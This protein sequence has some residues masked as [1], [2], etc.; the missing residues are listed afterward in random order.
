M[1][2]QVIKF[3]YY[4]LKK[5]Y[6]YLKYKLFFYRYDSNFE[7]NDF[8][9]INLSVKNIEKN[10]KKLL[11]KSANLA[12][13]NLY[14]IL[15][16]EKV[17][18]KG[19]DIWH[20]DF[21]SGYQWKKYTYYS[22]IKYGDK[23]G[24]DV[25]IPWE[26]S[27]NHHLVT[28]A[29]AYHLTRN[30][31]YLKK[32]LSDIHSW[33]DSN[34]IFYGV[35]WVCPMEVAIRAC[36]FLVAYSIF[37]NSAEINSKIEEKILFSLAEH[38]WFIR[39][40]LEKTFDGLTSNHYLADLM[41]LVFLGSFF[42]HTDYGKKWL[43]F[44]KQELI[45]EMDTQVYSDGSDYEASTAY[46]KLV[47]EFFFYATFVLVLN[48]KN[49][50]SFLTKAK[51]ILGFEFLNK[52]HKMF[53]VLKTVTK[54]N[55]EIS[56]F[57]DNDSGTVFH[58][59]QDVNLDSSFLL[60]LGSLFFKD[61]NLI[62]TDFFN[63]SVKWLFPVGNTSKLKLKPAANFSKS[64][65]KAGW[66]RLQN[67]K[68]ICMISAGPIGQTKNS[69]HSHNDKLSFEL[70]IKNENIIVDPG[71]Y[72]YTPQK[73]WRNKF[74]STLSHNTIRINR[75][76]QNQLFLKN[77]FKVQKKSESKIKEYSFKKKSKTCCFELKYKKFDWLH[78]RIFEL[79]SS[80]LKIQDHIF[81]TNIKELEWSFIFSPQ[82]KLFDNKKSFLKIKS[83]TQTL[84]FLIDEKLSW[85]IA[86]SYYSPVYGVKDKTR[87]ISALMKNKAE[88]DHLYFE[89]IISWET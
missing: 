74:R 20:R 7:K 43:K 29:Q 25:K 83:D 89:N 64:I 42:D 65:S 28:L 24:V 49:T 45:K 19:V 62:S 3:F 40:N 12:L 58:F 69:G 35:N 68:A 80:N 56:Q 59:N 67:K 73:K 78:R 11:I 18:V 9:F 52:L 50:G 57:G 4:R 16:Y 75:Q 1:L 27:R 22:N 21:I 39:H 34:P 13:K 5:Y 81:G 70:F 47:L 85:K 66:H 26:F 88:T 51:Q 44:A 72:V 76:E 2:K 36:N 54:P 6:L 82:I 8:K 33:I 41:G 23:K 79:N 10:E 84:K 87:K 55:G 38:G 30:S 31:K 32:Y 60:T 53:K 48:S 77:M 14:T 17:L 15:G 46:H 61:K 71:S 37:K 63:Y 86:A